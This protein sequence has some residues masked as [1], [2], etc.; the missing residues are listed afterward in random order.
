MNIDFNSKVAR[1]RTFIDR[2]K[3]TFGQDT[4]YIRGEEA[5]LAAMLES[6]EGVAL[7]DKEAAESVVYFDLHLHAA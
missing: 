3:Q 6:P 1:Q 2:L 7:L 5:E 4:P